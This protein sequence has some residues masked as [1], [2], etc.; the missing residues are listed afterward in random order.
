MVQLAEAKESNVTLIAD[1]GEGGDSSFLFFL[2]KRVSPALFG[3]QM[4]KG[5]AQARNLTGHILQSNLCTSGLRPL[6]WK[7]TIWQT[8][9]KNKKIKS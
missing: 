2:S 4:E 8:Q 6:F 5:L 1:L 3:K 7:A 9:F